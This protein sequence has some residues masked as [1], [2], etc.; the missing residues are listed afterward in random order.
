MGGLDA[1]KSTS[2][3][4]CFGVLIA[5][6][7]LKALYIFCAIRSIGVRILPI[8]FTLREIGPFSA[9]M[10]VFLLAA[11]NT[12]F[13]LDI[14]DFVKSFFVVYLTTFLGETDLDEVEGVDPTSRVQSSGEV[15][16]DPP[17]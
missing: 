3:Q 5:I 14:H 15:L 7:W 12:Y 16:V 9:V 13:A 10:L 6:K 8:L 11:T 2:F 4:V 1:K 17:P